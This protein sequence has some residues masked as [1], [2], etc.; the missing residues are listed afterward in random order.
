VVRALFAGKLFSCREGAQI[1]G[2]WTCLLAEDEGLKQGLTQKLCGFCSPNSHLCRLVS[3]GSGNEDGSP[4][5]SGEA[6]SV[7][8]TPLFWQGT[9]PD[10]WSP[11]WDLSQKLS[12][13]DLGDVCWLCVQG[14]PVLVPTRRDLWPLSGWVFCFPNAVSGPIGLEQKLCSNHQW[15]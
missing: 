5:C 3:E 15:S 14:D 7:G 1:Y 13:R 12:S 4:R 11:K 9:C 10:V 2:V 8:W 6:L